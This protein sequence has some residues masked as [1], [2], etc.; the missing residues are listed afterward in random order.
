MLAGNSRQS[1][2]T[3][4]TLLPTWFGETFCPVSDLLSSIIN[5]LSRWWFNWLVGFGDVCSSFIFGSPR[6]YPTDSIG[7]LANSTR[8]QPMLTLPFFAFRACGSTVWSF[9]GKLFKDCLCWLSMILTAKMPNLHR[10][11]R[12]AH[13]GDCDPRSVATELVSNLQ[14]NLVLL[15]VAYR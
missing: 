3:E 1:T 7:V 6:K 13:D 5:I 2:F 15:S 11:V 8:L 9:Y 12:W 4:T 14:Y 10:K